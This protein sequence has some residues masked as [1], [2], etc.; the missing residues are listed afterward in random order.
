VILDLLNAYR[1]NL[2]EGGVVTR[3]SGMS[4]PTAG[5][6]ALRKYRERIE[7]CMERDLKVKAVIENAM[8]IVF[9]GAE[10]KF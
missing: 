8:G 2:I 4:H 5:G 6:N 10:C 1:G 9:N 3:P 7:V